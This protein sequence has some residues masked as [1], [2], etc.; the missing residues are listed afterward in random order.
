MATAVSL[1]SPVTILTITPASLHYYT[2]WGTSGLKG[3]AI[4]ATATTVKS[5]TTISSNNSASMFLT[6]YIEL[7]GIS[8]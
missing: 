4:P 7:A 2:A 6:S 5:F 8:E 1:T 3:S